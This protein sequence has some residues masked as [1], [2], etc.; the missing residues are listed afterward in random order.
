MELFQLKRGHLKVVTE[1]VEKF[2][3]VEE[4]LESRTI[5]HNLFRFRFR[6]K[7]LR[8]VQ[9]SH[10]INELI[11]NRISDRVPLHKLWV[12]AAKYLEL[13]FKQ[14]GSSILGFVRLRLFF[15]FPL[16]QCFVNTI[17]LGFY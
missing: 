6:G 7:V 14:A 2:P 13:I 1:V 11:L 3:D 17:L 15:R 9:K 4:S 5:N 10:L 16:C 12:E 8:H